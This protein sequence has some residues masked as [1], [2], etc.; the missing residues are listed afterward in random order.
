MFIESNTESADSSLLAGVSYCGLNTL[1]ARKRSAAQSL[2]KSPS[3]GKR[4]PQK[5]PR[6]VGGDVGGS[7]RRGRSPK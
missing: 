1:R 7:K 2:P 5:V 4:S 3:V 6:A